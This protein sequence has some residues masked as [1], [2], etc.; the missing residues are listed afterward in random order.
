MKSQERVK[1]KGQSFQET[2]T[3][4]LATYTK[5]HH[6]PSS[7][8]YRNLAKNP[9]FCTWSSFL[10]ESSE[11][12]LQ[13]AFS[14]TQETSTSSSFL[15]LAVLLVG[16]EATPL[17]SAWTQPRYP[18]A[19]ALV[20][21][22][23]QSSRQLVTEQSLKAKRP[24]PTGQSGGWRP[25]RATREEWAAPRSQTSEG[26]PRSSSAVSAQTESPNW[27]GAKN[28]QDTA[29]HTAREQLIKNHTEWKE[30]KH[31]LCNGHHI[32]IKNYKHFRKQQK[33]YMALRLVMSSK[34]QQKSQYTKCFK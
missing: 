16:T 4:K 17:L 31:K 14:W 28:L 3:G 27:N 15:P 9:P 5:E 8:S 19:W 26:S 22:R 20:V 24:V 6:W 10:P 11:M 7:R 1:R 12:D 23:R 18:E 29:Q 13:S 2:V 33:I 21:L 34:T 30:H 25:L 32:S